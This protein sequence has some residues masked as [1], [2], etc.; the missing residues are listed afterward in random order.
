MAVDRVVGDPLKVVSWKVLDAA[1]A[2][3]GL[4]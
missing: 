1:L 4:D 3:L 2:R